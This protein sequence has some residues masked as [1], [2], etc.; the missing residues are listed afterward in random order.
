MESWHLICKMVSRTIFTI[1]K[2]TL[3]LFTVTLFF[4]AF[5]VNEEVIYTPVSNHNFAA[6]EYLGYD[7]NY[8]IFNVAKGQM[9]ID[10]NLYKINGRKSY[11]IDVIGKTT[12]IAGWLT[13]VDDKWGVYV[14]K[15]SLLPHISYRMIKENNYRKNERVLFD[16]KTDK[17]EYK[18]INKETGKYNPSRFFKAPNDVRDMISSFMYLRTLDYSKIKVGDVIAVDA[19]FEDEFYDFRMIYKGKEVVKTKFGKVNAIKLVP[20][21]P[22]NKIFKGENSISVW[23]SD[24]ENKIPV[25]I[26]AK[27]FVGKMVV[28]LEKYDGLLHKLNFVKKS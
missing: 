2:K 13:K 10:K 27:M 8:G 21:M 11:K 26:V 4:S 20:I 1:M 3:L 19:F 9:V 15:G 12:G 18:L 6:G 16:H 23:L 5:I 28:G 24:D 22:D 7:V 17:I 14:D 25:R